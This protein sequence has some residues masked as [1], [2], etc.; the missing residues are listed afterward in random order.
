V[1]NTITTEKNIW[2]EKMLM[3]IGHVGKNELEQSINVLLNIEVWYGI[4]IAFSVLDNAI[5]MIDD[6]II[7]NIL[8]SVHYAAMNFIL[9]KEL[10]IKDLEPIDDD[11][12]DD[13]F[14]DNKTLFESKDLKR[15]ELSPEVEQ[16]LLTT[17]NQLIL[18][19][20][21]QEFDLN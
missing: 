1:K 21:R 14:G 7:H 12:W 18:S 11:T 13:L 20:I 8:E 9:E 16:E 6:Q 3:G 10:G 5:K 17:F 4:D 2:L 19:P 15:L